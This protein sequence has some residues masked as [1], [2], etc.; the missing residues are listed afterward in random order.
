[1][2]GQRKKNITSAG[3]GKELMR[4]AG[5]MPIGVGALESEGRIWHEE[6]RMVVVRGRTSGYGCGDGVLVTVYHSVD[7]WFG[8]L[9]I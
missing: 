6:M 8:C 7:S 1:M 3:W 4:P 2:G 5:R 9:R